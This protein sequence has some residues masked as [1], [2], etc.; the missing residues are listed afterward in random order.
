MLAL[1]N[2]LL[3]MRLKVSAFRACLASFNVETVYCM[4]IE[5]CF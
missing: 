4:R 2:I 1:F 5:F 3:D